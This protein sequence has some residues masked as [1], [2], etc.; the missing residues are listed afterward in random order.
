MEY[1]LLSAEEIG[2]IAWLQTSTSG[3][4][5]RYLTLHMSHLRDSFFF[6]MLL[7]RAIKTRMSL[8]LLNT[9]VSGDLNGLAQGGLS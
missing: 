4:V 2:G 5:D 7:L 1:Q 8:V 6:V 3:S 9:F